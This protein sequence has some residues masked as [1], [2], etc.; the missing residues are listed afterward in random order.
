MAELTHIT[1]DIETLGFASDTVVLSIGAAAFTFDAT[2][3]NVYDDYVLNGFYAKLDASEQIGKYSRTMDDDTIN[4]WKTQPEEARKVTRPS[5]EDLP[6]REALLRL[7]AWINASGYDYKNSFAWSRGTYFDYP[8]LEHMYKQV[9]LEPGYNGW[10]IRDTKTY[11]DVLQGTS[12]GL[13]NKKVLPKGF[14]HHD[15]LHD[16]AVDAYRMVELFRSLVG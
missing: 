1:I 13:Y 9:G 2:R 4:W 6:M 5:S 7:N 14:I 10:K 3:P 12:H 11:F 15:A 8:K 16:A